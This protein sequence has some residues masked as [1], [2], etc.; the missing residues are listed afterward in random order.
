[1]KDKF[2]RLR[3]WLEAN[4]LFVYLGTIAAYAAL[5][6]WLILATS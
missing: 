5:M 4:D 3:G 1:M 2:E 6:I